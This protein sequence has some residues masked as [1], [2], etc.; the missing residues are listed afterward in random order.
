MKSRTYISERIT[1][2]SD[3]E[4]ILEKERLLIEVLNK[5]LEKNQP[6]MNKVKEVSKGIAKCHERASSFEFCLERRKVRKRN[7]I[8]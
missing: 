7:R 5:E 3:L 4:K 8:S 6:E 2:I 1:N